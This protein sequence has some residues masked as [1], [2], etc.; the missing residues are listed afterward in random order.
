M[1]NGALLTLIAVGI[2]LAVIGLFTAPALLSVGRQLA[3]REPKEECYEDEDG[4]STPEAVAAYSAKIPKVLILVFA[5]LGCA[6]SIAVTV[7]SLTTDIQDG[8]FIE[9][10]L[11]L[12]AWVC[13]HRPDTVIAVSKGCGY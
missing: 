12:A 10:W 11:S 1:Q 3:K 9:N 7:L 8:L 4:K 5:V 13:S 2:G 6:T